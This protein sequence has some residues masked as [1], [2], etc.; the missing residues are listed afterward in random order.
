MHVSSDARSLASPSL[1]FS[2]FIDTT[3]DL[4]ETNFSFGG[5]KVCSFIVRL[6]NF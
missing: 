2:L 1:S 6:K 3:V 4:T 5:H